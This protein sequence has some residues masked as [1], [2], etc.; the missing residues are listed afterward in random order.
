MLKNY[1]KIAWRNIWKNKLF[2]AINVISLAIGLSASF[3][4]GLMVYYDFSFDTFHEDG[5]RIYR[6]VTDFETPQGNY[7]NGGVT[8]PM[9]IAAKEQLTGV[10]QSAYF[11]NWWISEAKAEANKQTFKDPERIILTEASYFDIFQYKWIAGSKAT[12]LQQPNSVVLTRKRAEAY[13]PNMPLAAVMG[14]SLVYDGTISATVSGIVEDFDKRT[15]LHFNEFIS[16]ETAKQTE[17]SDQIF[18]DDW[19]NTNNASQLYIKIA[20]QSTPEQIKTQLATLSEA[21]VDAD[22]LKYNNKRTFNLQALSD[23]HFDHEYGAY[24]YSGYEADKGILI[25]LV[26]V[27]LFLLLLG[28]INFINLNTAQAASRAKEIGVRKTMG[29]SKRQLVLQFLGETFLLTLIAAL[30]SVVFCVLALKAFDSFMAEGIELSLMLT[31]WFA[32]LVVV[33]VIVITLLSGFYP[34]VVLSRFKPA[35]VLKGSVSS[36]KEKGVLRQVL[37]VSQFAIAQVFVIA[38]LLVGKQ[39]Y[40]MMHQDLGF[41]TEAV[42]YLQTPWDD[43][44]IDKRLVLEQELKRIPEIQNVS[45]GGMPPAS[46]NMAT[47]MGIFKKDGQEFIQELQILNGDTEYLKLYDIELLAGRPA[48]ND[49]IEEYVINETGMRA[50]GFKDPEKIVG[51]YLEL[52]SHQ[53]LIVGVMQDFNQRSL[54]D[55]VMPLML[56]GDTSRDRRTNF[57]TLHV[58]LT[59]ASSGWQN[60][61]AKVEQ[62]YQEVYP[63]EEFRLSFVDESI[64]KFYKQEQRIATLLNWATGLAVLISCLGLLG[65][66][67]HTTSR[68]TKEIGIRKVLGASILQIN[69]LLCTD[70]LKLVIV[71]YVIALPIAWWGLQQWLEDYAYKTE[72]SWWVFALSGLGMMLLAVLIMSFK[73]LKAAIANPVK[74]LRTE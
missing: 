14:Q 34:G 44:S 24:G 35:R 18:G 71:A 6:V 69:A 1:I 12:A 16:L 11:Y 36:S 47:R 54:K 66:V 51:Q 41:N 60:T 28:S 2:S 50:F 73:T 23:L 72:M 30:C 10:E 38:T 49:T 70:F 25:S 4:I 55:K 15:D 13:F 63:G 3:V 46:F 59:G 62:L 17:S 22:M 33:L 43:F 37:T 61:I 8:P 9:R 27:A 45:L 5:D 19:G 39:I 57:R 56:T 20:Q 67:I 29:S 58:K 7:K 64:S 52:N 68:R 53:R 26:F 31:P 74:A 65:L 32:A 40:Y 42:A 21:H 48:L